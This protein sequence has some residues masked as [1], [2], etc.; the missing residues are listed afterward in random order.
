MPLAA[1]KVLPNVIGVLIR[2]RRVLFL[3]GIFNFRLYLPLGSPKV[4]LSA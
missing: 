1:D 2:R 3:V 4:P